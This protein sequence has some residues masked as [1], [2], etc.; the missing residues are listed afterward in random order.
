MK[1]SRRWIWIGVAVALLLVALALATPASS[2]ISKGSTFSRA[3]DGYGA[4]YAYMQE[5]GTPIQRWQRPPESRSALGTDRLGT[6]RPGTDQ[7]VTLLQIVPPSLARP[8][9]LWTDW[10]ADGNTLI[11]LTS[12]QSVTPAPFSSLLPSGQDPVRIE[13]RRR[14]E[15]IAA[16]ETALLSDRYGTVVWRSPVG[17]GQLI[18]ATTPY[19]GANA[20]QDAP[21]NFAFLADLVTSGGANAGSANAGSAIW[22]D[23]YLHGY[24]DLA[25]EDKQPSQL[26]WP[27]Y[28]ART[29]LLLVLV[30]AIALGLLLVVGQRRLGPAASIQPP[31]PNNSEAYVNALAGV[32]RRAKSTKFVVETVAQAERLQLQKSLGLGST[33][34]DEETLVAAWAQQTRQPPDRLAR[35]LQLGRPASSERELTS[36][37]NALEAVRQSTRS[38]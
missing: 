21:G 36:W 31:S 13:T 22:V 28:L 18:Q 19:I 26:S 34:V 15:E 32:L 10:V 33:L 35:L 6:D 16:D 37:L 17:S 20:Y 25:P 8:A 2:P 14:Y 5:R 30:Q 4:W 7:P 38:G 11:V 27:R 23:E 12:Q 3:P 1:G 24:R 29:P 9:G